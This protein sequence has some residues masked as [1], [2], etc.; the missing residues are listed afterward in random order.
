MFSSVSSDFSSSQQ[1]SPARKKSRTCS[2]SPSLADENPHDPAPRTESLALPRD[3]ISLYA[4]DV[5]EINSHSEDHQDL[6][7]EAEIH[8]VSRDS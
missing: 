8:N 3:H 1:R 5:D 2:R 4:D 6:T 7:P